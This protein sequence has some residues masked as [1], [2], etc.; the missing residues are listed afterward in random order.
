MLGRD[1]TIQNPK[2]IVDGFNEFFVSA[3]SSLASTIKDS[4]ENPCKL[5]NGQFSTLSTFHPHRPKEV[6]DMIV[7]PQKAMMELDPLS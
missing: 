2:E 3:G 6:H 1:G 7:T 4:N 5:I